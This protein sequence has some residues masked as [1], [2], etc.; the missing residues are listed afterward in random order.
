MTDQQAV[1][2]LQ[3][4]ALWDRPLTVN[5]R[6]WITFLRLASEDTDPAPTLRTVQALRRAFKESKGLTEHS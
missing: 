5:E 3:A 6:Q 2:V 4:K 1:M